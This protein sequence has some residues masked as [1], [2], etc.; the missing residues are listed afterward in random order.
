M[1]AKSHNK[2]SV[3]E[4]D[5]ALAELEAEQ[6]AWYAAWRKMEA[7]KA[8]LKAQRE[9]ANATLIIRIGKYLEQ[10]SAPSHCK[11]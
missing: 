2:L 3:A 11:A 10:Q 8:K 7:R 1:A 6:R 4:L 9:K 5:K